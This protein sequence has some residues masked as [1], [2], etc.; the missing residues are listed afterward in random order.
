MHIQI[1]IRY[2]SKS[3]SRDS[4]ITPKSNYYPE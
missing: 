3:Y 4:Q 1:T 2:I